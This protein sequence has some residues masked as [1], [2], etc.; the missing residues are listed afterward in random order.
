MGWGCDIF[1]GFGRVSS[2][3]SHA[4][5][6]FFSL[7]RFLQ[8]SRSLDT[9]YFHHVTQPSEMTSLRAVGRGRRT[10]TCAWCVS[11]V[12]FGRGNS[13]TPLLESD[14]SCP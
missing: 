7:F 10:R 8:A 14:L 5:D 4:S 12:V 13:L 1:R 6:E 9:A 11:A 3:H 2:I